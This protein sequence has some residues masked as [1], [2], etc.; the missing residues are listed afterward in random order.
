MR[1]PDA[2]MGWQVFL[3]R[4]FLG[5]FVAWAF[6]L[7]PAVAGQEFV[8]VS[9][10]S[11]DELAGQAGFPGAGSSRGERVAGAELGGGVGEHVSEPA[12]EVVLGAGGLGDRVDRGAGVA[13]LA[14]GRAC[15]CAGAAGAGGVTSGVLPGGAV[16]A[17][18]R[19]AAGSVARVCAAG[20]V[21]RGCGQDRDGPLRVEGKLL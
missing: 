4:G 7:C 11:L 21:G 16:R 12:G 8:V 10:G 20:R 18:G 9:D 3:G 14:G 5:Q 19:G 6:W 15:G 2:P 1:R 13:R 17:P